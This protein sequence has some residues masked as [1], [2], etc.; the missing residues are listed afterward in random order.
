VIRRLLFLILL[1]AGAV[2][3]DERILSYHSDILI[4]SD[5]WIEV[6]ETI[7]VR[8]E[9]NQIRR[10][11]FRDYPTDYEDQYGN[12]FEALYEPQ[13]VLRNN[14]P[15]P[16][17]SEEMW[18]GVR[19]YFGSSDR[20][21]EAG[22]HT[23]TYR[24]HAGRMIGFFG[25]KDELW[26]NVTGLGW[27]FPIDEASA[28][29]SF[30]FSVAPEALEIDAWQGP[31]LSSERAESALDNQDGVNFQASRGLG[32]NENLSIS[33]RWPK[34]FV[35]EPSDLQR[36][37]WLLS[38]NL[39]L[40]I[41]LAGLAALLGYYIP[42]WKGYGKDPQPGVIIT[43]YEP[44]DDFSPA[45]LRYIAN[46]GYDDATMTAAVISLA[47]KGYLRINAGDEHHS[48]QQTD[49]GVNPAPLTAGEKALH[50]ALFEDGKRV[51]LIDDNHELIGGAKKA[52]ERS[53]RRDYY[54]RYF[55]TNGLLNLPPLIVATITAIIALLIGPSRIVMVTIFLMAV[56]ISAFV[57]LLRRPTRLGRALLDES[58][59]FEEYLRIAEKDEMN[60]RYPPEKTPYLFERYLPFAVALGVEQEWADRFTRIFAE[61]EGPNDTAWHPSWYNGSWNNFDLS[62]TTNS[63]SSSLGSA[64]SSSST[65]PGSSSSGGGGGFSGGGGG[66]GGGGGW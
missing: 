42:V 62:V 53:L 1:M 55:V 18:N 11:I 31:W 50:D 34:G 64:I 5:G 7:R 23:Y 12:N 66:G 52:H 46:M 14:L 56:C 49:P 4:R 21:L 27:N 29:V 58:L 59:G 3:A 15:E 51:T 6:T 37:I 2:T 17:H 41:A 20:M 61:L 57:M 40:L 10:G 30:E 19:T 28:A 13:S 45:S 24:Y 65:P 39:N 8:A 48:L 16:F 32:L 38:D 35:P 44:P 26:W 25:D 54:K 63:V 22:E 33:V 47:V 60:L 36:F 43:R 9:G